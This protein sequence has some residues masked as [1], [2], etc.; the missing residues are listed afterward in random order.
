MFLLNLRD[1]SFDSSTPLVTFFPSLLICFPMQAVLNSNNYAEPLLPRR[2]K[3]KKKDGIEKKKTKR[4]KKETKKMQIAAFWKTDSISLRLFLFFCFLPTP[5]LQ[6]FDHTL[7]SHSTN[8][9]RT[10]PTSGSR[11]LAYPFCLWSNFGNNLSFMSLGLWKRRAIFRF[12]LKPFFIKKDLVLVL[13]FFFFQKLFFL[14]SYLSRNW[15]LRW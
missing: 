13:S 2:Q 1:L 6:R 14:S 8:H 4:R 9:W 15:W 7:T 3:K 11:L 12:L 10:M 5:Y